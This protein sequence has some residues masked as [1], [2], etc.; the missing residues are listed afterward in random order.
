[1]RKKPA[2][3]CSNVGKTW[4]KPGEHGTVVAKYVGKTT[5]KPRM[6][7]TQKPSNRDRIWK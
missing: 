3:C 6:L 2:N 1:L 7:N 4:E 5:W